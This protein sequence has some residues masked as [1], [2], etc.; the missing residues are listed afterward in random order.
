VDNGFS[1]GETSEMI[2]NKSSRI[3]VS[4]KLC[5]KIWEEKRPQEW[6]AFLVQIGDIKKTRKN[7]LASSESKGGRYLLDLPEK[8][9]FMIRAIYSSEELS[10]NKEF[11]REFASR[12]PRFAVPETL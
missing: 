12:Y 7:K 8:L 10:M 2:S 9:M 5:I 3:D 6:K 4:L 11:M 1:S